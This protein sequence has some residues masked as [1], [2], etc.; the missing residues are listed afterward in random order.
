MDMAMPLQQ[1]VQIL[2]THSLDKHMGLY[3]LASQERKQLD[4]LICII[5]KLYL[6]QTQA[7]TVYTIQ[8]HGIRDTIGWPTHFLQAIKTNINM[9]HKCFILE[10]E[11]T[12]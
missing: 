8:M 3:Q 2:Y 11:L 7:L 12:N 1:L 6:T 4:I 10:L 5:P 9:P